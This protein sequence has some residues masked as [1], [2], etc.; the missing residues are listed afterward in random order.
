MSHNDSIHLT[1]RGCQKRLRVKASLAGKRVRCP[2]E[3]CGELLVVPDTVRQES[4][5]PARLPRKNAA[6][7]AAAEPGEDVT[8]QERAR[9]TAPRAAKG[10]FW[11]KY[12]GVVILL[13]IVFGVVFAW[14]LGLFNLLSAA[15]PPGVAKVIRTEKLLLHSGRDSYTAVNPGKHLVLVLQLQG[16]TAKQLHDTPQAQIQVEAA[17]QKHPCPIT[18]THGGF[19]DRVLLAFTVPRQ[20]QG[21]TLHL[22]NTGPM[23]F[24]SDTV[25]LPTW[26]LPGLDE[27]V[28]L[29]VAGVLTVVF[30]VLAVV[31]A[32]VVGIWRW[33]RRPSPSSTR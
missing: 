13:E 28:S 5:E 21:M 33:V 16:V 25:I 11:W 20:D 10:R 3:S 2:N 22:G 1:C 29:I 31:G 12:L 30:P 8:P 24:R 9:A 32:I 27:P 7:K 6:R 26:E 4:E 14:Q 23:P 18:N 15:P 19:P 17:G